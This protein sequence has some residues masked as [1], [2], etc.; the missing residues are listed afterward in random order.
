MKLGITCQAGTGGSGILATEL[1]LALAARG[2]EVHFVTLEQPF[3]LAGFRENVYTHYVEDVTYPVFRVPPYTLSLAS[4]ISEVAEE[5]GIEI[6]HAHY[7]IPNA[8]AALFARDMLPPERRFCLVTTVHG[9]D[10]TLVGGHPSFYRATRFAMENSCVVTAVSDWLSRETE[11]E[12]ALTVPV[13][14]IHNFTD[15]ERFKPKPAV[16]RDRL[17]APG[18]RIVMHVSNFRPVKRVTDVVRAF[19]RM[20]EEVDA[21]LLLVGDGPERLSAV[22]VAKQLGV[23]DKITSLGNVENIEDLLPAADLVFQ[24][25]EHESFGLVP[26][27]AMACG[28]PV[29]AT[30]SGGV[31]EVVEHGVTGY[32][33]GV[34][35]ID[36][37]VRH[38]VAILSD[39]ALRAALGARA[40][41]RVLTRFPVD[42]IVGQY[43]A[44]YAEVLERRRALGGAPH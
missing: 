40:R 22:G 7:A 41:E 12:F 29:L 25:S 16:N 2:H 42:R 10:I 9:T 38:G 1:G 27:E 36:A 43:E 39:P 14:T 8:A 11:R 13:R 23:L 33:C 20:L 24:P 3:R 18:E 31:T 21:R 17:A 19:A 15:P 28:V 32:L 37:M 30:A 4:K 5:H 26:L 35:D 44:L 34:G 6:W